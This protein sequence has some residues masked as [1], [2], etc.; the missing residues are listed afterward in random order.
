M[1]FIDWYTSLDVIQCHTQD[2]LSIPMYMYIGKAAQVLI[3]DHKKW[4]LS[5]LFFM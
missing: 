4:Q 1:I 5:P 2:I 3:N